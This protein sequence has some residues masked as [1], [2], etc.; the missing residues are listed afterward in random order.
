MNNIVEIVLQNYHAL[1]TRTVSQMK[2][3]KDET[4]ATRGKEFNGISNT[5]KV[6]SR[7]SGWRILQY[8]LLQGP[9][10]LTSIVKTFIACLTTRLKTWL[11]CLAASKSEN[12][13]QPQDPEIG[14]QQMPTSSTAPGESQIH[15]SSVRVAVNNPATTSSNSATTG[16]AKLNATDQKSLPDLL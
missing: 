4:W 13:R 15:P 14:L 9:T 5:K 8:M 10:L 6:A 7:L 12:S 1:A 16:L 11:T 2:V 3:D